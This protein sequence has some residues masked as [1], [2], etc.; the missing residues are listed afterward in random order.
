[1]GRQTGPERSD[2]MDHW[3]NRDCVMLAKD[4]GYGWAPEIRESF[5]LILGGCRVKRDARNDAKR[6]RVLP[7]ALFA[8]CNVSVKGVSVITIK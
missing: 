4:H 6:D 5:Y 3:R 1:M 8:C 7:L 2:L